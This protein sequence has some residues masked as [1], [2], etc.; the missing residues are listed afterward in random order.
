MITTTTIRIDDRIKKA[1]Q[2]EAEQMKLRGKFSEYI[3][4]LIRADLKKKGITVKVEE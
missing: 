1:G 3:E 2:S 4:L